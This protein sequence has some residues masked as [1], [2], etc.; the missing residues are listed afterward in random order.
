VDQCTH[1]LLMTISRN[2][3]SLSQ[4]EMRLG[5]VSFMSCS[6]HKIRFCVRISRRGRESGVSVKTQEVPRIKYSKGWAILSEACMRTSRR[7]MSEGLVGQCIL[8]KRLTLA[9]WSRKG[10]L[11]YGFPSTRSTGV[12]LAKV[13]QSTLRPDLRDW[14]K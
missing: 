2:F 14:S 3:R 7:W 9:F 11:G 10:S 1:R 5:K 4:K 6:T 13:W 8:A 12:G